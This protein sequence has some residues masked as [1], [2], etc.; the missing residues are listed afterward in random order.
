MKRFIA[1]SAAAVMLT[2]LPSVPAQAAPSAV[3]TKPAVKK[4]G[5]KPQAGKRSSVTAPKVATRQAKVK[6]QWTLAGKRLKGQTRRF[7]PVRAAHVGKVLRVRVVVTAPRHKK[8][9]QVVKFG[10]V[11]HGQIPKSWAKGQYGIDSSTRND[12]KVGDQLFAYTPTLTKAAKNAGATFSRQ[13]TLD[14]QPIPGETR[15]RYVATE[16]AVDKIVGH[17]FTLSAPGYEARVTKAQLP[18]PVR[19]ANVQYD[20]LYTYAGVDENLDEFHHH[21]NAVE[22][23]VQDEKFTFLGGA[24]YHSYDFWDA[25]QQKRIKDRQPVYF[26]GD[27]EFKID[28]HGNPIPNYIP[29]TKVPWPL[30]VTAFNR[31]FTFAHQVVDFDIRFVNG[32]YIGTISMTHPDWAPNGFVIDLED[33]ELTKS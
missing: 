30:Y 16:D 12:P 10:R 1:A 15:R 11:A 28:K 7:I 4:L 17:T 19:A 26:A 3:V 20:G 23:R 5:K 25:S 6:Y 18:I 24:A 32:K 27:I 29:G 8:S 9:V 31:D 21:E 33:L 2:T 14:G 13:W 22:F